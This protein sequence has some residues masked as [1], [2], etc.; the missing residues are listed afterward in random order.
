MSWRTRLDPPRHPGKV[1][2]LVQPLNNLILAGLGIFGVGVHQRGQ[3]L[4]GCLVVVD[5]VRHRIDRVCLHR[6]GQLAQIAVVEY[7]AARSHLE[8]ALLLLL[9]ALHKLFVAHHL[10]PEEPAADR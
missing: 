8:G 9:G 6:H 3:G 10:Q 2:A 1:L 4:S 7:A 5:L